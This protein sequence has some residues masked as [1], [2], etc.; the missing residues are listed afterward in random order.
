M[1]FFFIVFSSHHL[2][3]IQ[4]T[5]AKT[6]CLKLYCECFSG[7]RYCGSNCECA[8]CHNKSEYDVEGGTRYEAI[9]YILFRKPDAFD[10]ETR[11]RI[12]PKDPRLK[13]GYME[14][15]KSR[16]DKS[17]AN[18]KRGEKI[19]VGSAAGKTKGKAGRPKKN[20]NQVRIEQV[21][22]QHEVIDF[23]PIEFPQLAVDEHDDHSDL[24]GTFTKPLFTEPSRPL[25]IAYSQLT[26]MDYQ[27]KIAR[28]K[29]VDLVKECKLLREKLQQK[30][31]AISLVDDEI[32]G[33]DKQLGTWTRKVFDL[34]LE[35]PCEW[36]RNYQKL[37]AF[38]EK[39]GKLPSKKA[40]DEEEKSLSVWLDNIRHEMGDDDDDDK[41]KRLIEDYPHRLERLKVLGVTFGRRKNDDTFEYMLQKLIEYK[42]EHGTLR[43]PSDEQCEKSKNLEL[44]ALHKWV[45]SIVLSHR[46]GKISPDALRQLKAIGFSFDKWCF[47]KAKKKKNSTVAAAGAKENTDHA[48]IEGMAV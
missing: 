34:E 45:K 3:N 10:E 24:A 28:Q 37:C 14:G 11:K 33:C 12:P 22:A 19:P 1:I 20:A 38:K 21:A 30:K 23:S 8:T 13:P 47:S 46:S 18:K 35:E 43:F 36:N 31:L 40:Q 2:R 16:Q 42:E 7:G 26:K 32:K 9:Q 39:H 4:C 5:C 44:I 15:L 6:K 17:R 25:E 41:K 48:A 27:N 29:K